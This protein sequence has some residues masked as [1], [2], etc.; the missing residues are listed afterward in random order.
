MNANA[1]PATIPA[2]VAAVMAMLWQ[3][4]PPSQFGCD[5]DSE[6][7]VAYGLAATVPV[8][9]DLVGD[10]E[11]RRDEA[12]ALVRAAV[13]AR[14]AHPFDKAQADRIC[15]AVQRMW[16]VARIR[17]HPRAA[18]FGSLLAALRGARATAKQVAFAK[19]LIAEVRS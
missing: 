19:Q 14:S 15:R 7:A 4:G 10:D 18:G 12:K 11:A 5:Q 2:A 1:A 8:L 17:R 3:Y 13:A 6:K 16:M 9:C